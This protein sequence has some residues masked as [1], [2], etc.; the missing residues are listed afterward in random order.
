MTWT[1]S[2]NEIDFHLYLQ[3]CIVGWKPVAPEWQLSHVITMLTSYLMD[4]NTHVIARQP[5]ITVMSYWNS[6][7]DTLWHCVNSVSYNCV[8]GK[9]KHMD[10]SGTKCKNPF[11]CPSIYCNLLFIMVFIWISWYFAMQ[12]LISCFM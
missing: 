8:H 5:R 10:T 11:F 12:R 3:L 2:D 6:A 1:R 4:V 9:K 7:L